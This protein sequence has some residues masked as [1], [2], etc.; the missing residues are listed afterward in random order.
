M[1]RQWRSDRWAPKAEEIGAIR[2][3]IYFSVNS[4]IT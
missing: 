4:L 3:K 1:F 2:Q